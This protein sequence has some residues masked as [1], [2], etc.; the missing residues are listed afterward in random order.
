MVE[1]SGGNVA[2]Y[3]QIAR[4]IGREKNSRLVACVLSRAE[5]TGDT[6][7]PRGQPC[8]AACAGSGRSRAFCWREKG[9]N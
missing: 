2:T 6:L 8:G 1:K 4:L 7:P 3:G 5:F 9:S